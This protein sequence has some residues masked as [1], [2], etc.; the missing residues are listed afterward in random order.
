MSADILSFSSFQMEAPQIYA[1]SLVPRLEEAIIFGDLPVGAR[2]TEEELCQKTGVSRSPVREALRVLERD[3]LIVREPR[4][5]V[6]VS[7][8][9][10]VE[11]DQLYAC[12]MSLETMAVKLAVQNATDEEIKR[13]SSLHEVCVAALSKDNVRDHFRANVEMGECLFSAS[14]NKTLIRLLG[15]IH[16]QA[17]RYRYLAYKRSRAVREASVEANGKIVQALFA[18]DEEDASLM[19]KTSIE[20]AHEVIKQCLLESDFV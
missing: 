2:L 3:G 20:R 13:Y 7:D 5:G 4:R 17:L 11:L 12:R 19:L 16:K 18:R 15:T 14:H 10:V 8:L 6:R 9:T 1:S